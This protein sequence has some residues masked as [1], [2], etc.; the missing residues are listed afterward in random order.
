MDG[1][2]TTKALRELGYTGVIIALTANALVGNEEMFK[3]NGFD[4]YIPKP[5]D[6]MQLDAVL[7]KYIRDTHAKQNMTDIHEEAHP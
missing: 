5:I 4:G 3:R 7:N 2:E 1:I 6:V